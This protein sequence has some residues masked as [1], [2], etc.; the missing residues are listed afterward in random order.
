MSTPASILLHLDNNFDDSSYFSLSPAPQAYNSGSAP[1]LT[2]STSVFG[3]YCAQFFD[4]GYID[5][6]DPTLLEFGTND[7]TVECWINIGRFDTYPA[8]F[9]PDVSIGG[10]FCVLS[11]DFKV[12]AGLQPYGWAIQASHSMIADNWY[13]LAITRSSG[14]LRVF[15]DGV[16]L[17]SVTDNNNYTAYGASPSCIGGALG[18]G[19]SLIGFMDEIRIV[20]NLA[21]YT[22]EFAPPVSPLSID[23]DPYTVP[24]LTPTPTP[25]STPI[26]PTPTSTPIQPTPTPTPIQPTPTPTPIQPTGIPTAT[27]TPTIIGGPTF[28]PTPTPTATPKPTC[29]QSPLPTPTPTAIPLISSVSITYQLSGGNDNTDPDL[30]LGGEIS[31]RP[32]VLEI[33]FKDVKP[34]EAI[35]GKTDYRCFYIKNNSLISTLYQS[36]V[37]IYYTVSNNTSL[38]LGF[39]TSDEI[40]I[41]KVLNNSPITGGSFDIVYLSANN[42]SYTVSASWDSNNTTWAN[43]IQTAINSIK[44]LEDVKVNTL[45]SQSFQIN[46]GGRAGKRLHNLISIT[47]N[48]SSSGSVSVFVNKSVKGS[49]IN[50]SSDFIDS[51][52][53]TP[54]NVVFTTQPYEIGNLLPGEAVPVWV[55]R[56]VPSNAISIE[57]DGLTIRTIGSTLEI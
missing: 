16:I 48:L 53:T 24:P 2:N 47:N 10:F 23:A 22:S 12:L 45:D 1:L 26:Q 5:A 17:D 37:Y 32:I 52:A 43:N 29:A 51:E 30:S 33:L 19:N 49:P 41:I 8:I 42:Q 11:S 56:V 18:S 57:N 13:H 46:F 55:K 9:G 21:V 35:S 39:I 38:S 28:T 25:T 50:T 27:P 40:Q 31:T 7:F 14:I 4:H 44:G 36:Q 20:K 3:G 54:F 15:Q 34:S 6:N